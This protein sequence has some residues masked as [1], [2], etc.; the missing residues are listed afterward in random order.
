MHERMEEIIKINK[1]RYFERNHWPLNFNGLFPLVVY[2][3]N[4]L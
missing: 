3:Y 2:G 4:G 1:S